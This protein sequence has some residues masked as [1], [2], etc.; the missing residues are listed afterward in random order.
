MNP[1]KRYLNFK[2]SLFLILCLL[3]G[4]MFLIL[5]EY[6]GDEKS[7]QA[8]PSFSE[9]EYS[10]MLEKRLSDILEKMEGVSDVTV[11][12][13]LEGGVSY[14]YAKKAESGLWGDSTEAVPVMQENANGSK[15]PILLGTSLP[16]VRGV[17][18]VCRS[19]ANVN[20]KRRIIGLVAS[21]LN[22]N[23]NQIFVS[24]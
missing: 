10:V 4:I 3:L 24:E 7:D 12:I 14:E 13:T 15:E 11:M 21:T 1:K 20:V 19:A 23:E 16:K 18:V 22:L 2:K 9:S 6:D 17:S 8:P 5:S